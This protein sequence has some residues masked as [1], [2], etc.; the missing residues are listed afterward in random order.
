MFPE[1]AGFASV[2]NLF[3]LWLHNV[4]EHFFW[5]RACANL[6][7]DN[8]MGTRRYADNPLE[9]GGGGG[10]DPTQDQPASSEKGK[11]PRAWS[12]P[13]LPKGPPDTHSP[14]QAYTRLYAPTLSGL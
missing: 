8:I 2:Y 5:N 4:W 3:F 10:V 1:T 6:L 7:P 11:R 13:L 14:G 9:P 12:A